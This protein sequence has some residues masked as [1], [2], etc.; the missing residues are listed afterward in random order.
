MTL[1]A[2]NVARGKNRQNSELDPHRLRRLF[3]ARLL[4]PALK[5]PWIHTVGLVEQGHP[6]IVLLGLDPGCAQ[7]G[8]IWVAAEAKQG[9]PVPLDTPKMLDGVAI[10]LIEVPGQCLATDLNRMAMWFNH[11]CPG[12]ARVR[13]ARLTAENSADT[14][15]R[16]GQDVS[17]TTWFTADL[18]FGHANIIQYCA[19]PFLD[20]DSMNNVLVDRWNESVKPADTVWVLGDVALGRI[21]ETLELVGELNGRKVLLAGNHD[22]CWSGHGDK[23]APWIE[24]YLDAGFDEVRHGEVNI[25]VGRRTMRASH[26]PYRGDSHDHDRYVDHRPVDSGAWLLHGHVHERWRQRGRMVNVGVDAWD[27]RPVSEAQVDALIEAGPAECDP[28][29]SRHG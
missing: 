27:Y 10:K 5:H 25:T 28:L 21:D 3:D 17:M 20:V 29:P 26:F 9:R 24:R 15:R 4:R 19:R 6:E 22:R 16:S 7:H 8:I 1:G 2:E 23:S 12:R 18:H 13:H 11:Y 14:A